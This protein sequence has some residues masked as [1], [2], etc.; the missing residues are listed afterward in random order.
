M[1]NSAHINPLPAT[2]CVVKYLGPTNTL[3][4]RVKLTFP[5]YAKSIVIPYDYTL[6]RTDD[7]AIAHLRTLGVECEHVS[8]LSQNEQAL[9]ISS[10]Y[11]IPLAIALGF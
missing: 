6:S 7:M 3:G 8:Y 2:L 1:N 10:L 11:S 9:T 4:S 5:R